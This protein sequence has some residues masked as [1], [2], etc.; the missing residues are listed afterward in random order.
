VRDIKNVVKNIFRLF[1]M[2]IDT[3]TPSEMQLGSA[4]KDLLKCHKKFNNALIKKIAANEKLRK[5]FISFS[6]EEG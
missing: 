6:E 5:A 4:L 2:W 3:S 1:Q